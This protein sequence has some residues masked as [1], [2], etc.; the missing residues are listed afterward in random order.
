MSSFCEFGVEKAWKLPLLYPFS[1]SRR[2]IRVEER[3]EIFFS[4]GFNELSPT[5]FSSIRYLIVEIANFRCNFEHFSS[6]RRLLVI[7]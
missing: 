7:A 2:N 4:I 1:R 6:F 3:K 5:I